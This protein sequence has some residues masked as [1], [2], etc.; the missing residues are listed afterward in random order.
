MPICLLHSKNCREYN[1]FSQPM[2]TMSNTNLS[3]NHELIEKKTSCFVLNT[4]RKK[5]RCRKCVFSVFYLVEKA[6]NIR[7]YILTISLLFAKNIPFSLEVS[8]YLTPAMMECNIGNIEGVSTAQQLDLFTIS[9]LKR[10]SKSK[11]ISFLLNLKFRL[12]SCCS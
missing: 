1:F 9:F 2:L 5:I 11:L 8:S 7:S 12:S 3:N 6:I 4:C 10:T